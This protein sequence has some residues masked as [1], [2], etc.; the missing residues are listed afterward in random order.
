MTNSKD[1]TEA[2]QVA[3]Y[4]YMRETVQSKPSEVQQQ[5]WAELQIV[6]GGMEYILSALEAIGTPIHYQE[7]TAQIGNSAAGRLNLLSSELEIR[8]EKGG[9]HDGDSN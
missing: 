1:M 5:R 2:A 8:S 7:L 4:F 3:A 6:M 9:Q